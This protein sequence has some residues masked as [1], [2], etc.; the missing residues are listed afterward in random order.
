MRS[1]LKRLLGLGV[2]LVIL[3]ELVRYRFLSLFLE[4]DKAFHGSSQALSR[5]PGLGGEYA[6]REFYRLTLEACCDDCCISF[7]TILSKRGA[8]IGRGVYIGTGCTL[9]LVTI[10][11]DV[12]IAS[13]VDI[14]S[15]SRQHHID[16]LDTP[17][18]EQGGTFERVTIGADTWIGNRAIV[19]ADVGRQCVVGAGSV[20]SKPLPDRCLAVGS[21]ARSVGTRGGDP[22]TGDD[23]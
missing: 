16:D 23:A 15:G 5:W 12:L 10:E 19:M 1:L 14:L 6:R 2:R 8:R 11:D 17:V 22:P 3:P 18:R 21:P 13:N 9:G 20:V 4:P 7:G